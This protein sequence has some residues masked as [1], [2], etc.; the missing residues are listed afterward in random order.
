[1]KILMGANMRAMIRKLFVEPIA[2][3]TLDGAPDAEASQIISNLAKMV[4][5]P[6]AAVGPVLTDATR[7]LDE[8]AVATP[9]T[10]RMLMAYVTGMYPHLTIIYIY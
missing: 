4:L 2:V 9:A 3:A 6:V 5:N 8:I 7:M 10:A 1:M